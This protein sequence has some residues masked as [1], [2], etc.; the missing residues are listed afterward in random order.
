MESSNNPDIRIPQIFRR[1]VPLN[2]AWHIN[3]HNMAFRLGDLPIQS[4]SSPGRRLDHTVF[5][6]EVKK[7]NSTRVVCLRPE[8]YGGRHNLLAR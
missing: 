7:T 8:R 3:S 4:N 1:R 5:T 6:M 2:R